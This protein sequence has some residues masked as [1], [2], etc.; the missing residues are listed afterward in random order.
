M[1]VNPEIERFLLELLPPRHPVLVE[2]EEYARQNQI[3]IVGPLVGNFLAQLVSIAR[4][5]RIFELGSAIGYSTAWLALAAGEGA[6]VHYT[7]RDQGRAE[8][9]RRYFARLGV[10]E[11]IRFHVGDAIEA[12]VRTPG[13]FDFIFNDISKDLYARVLELAPG[14]LRPG[15]LLVSDNALW[16]E[17]VLAPEDETSR[18]VR[19]FD[20]NSFQNKDFHCS[21][22]PLRDGL[23][24]AW[25]RHG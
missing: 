20:F 2:M 15:G 4:A 16:H 10:L 18:Q 3:P 7:D 11:R 5:R 14:K 17:R 9:A 24:L 8:L 21:L 23:L 19:E 12:L 1:I 22:V 25:K 13:E 6:E